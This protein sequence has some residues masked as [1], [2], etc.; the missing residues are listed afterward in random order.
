M[1]SGATWNPLA[2]KGRF[3]L[4]SLCA[5]GIPCAVFM[6][7][8]LGGNDYAEWTIL[9]MLALLASQLWAAL[10]WPYMRGVNERLK[11]AARDSASES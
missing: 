5:F 4:Y 9:I 10:M 2:S 3:F 8:W 1:P 7:F 11:R 6:V